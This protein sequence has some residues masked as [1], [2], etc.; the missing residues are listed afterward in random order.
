LPPD[1]RAKIERLLAR[2]E[3][4]LA[5]I[6]ELERERNAVAETAAPETTP[7]K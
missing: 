7:P 1:A 6:M 3:L 4:V 5:H 2:L